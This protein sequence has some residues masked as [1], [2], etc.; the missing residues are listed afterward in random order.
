MRTRVNRETIRT[1]LAILSE[2][3]GR[4]RTIEKLLGEKFDSHSGED[5]AEEKV[6]HE[7][8]ER[9]SYRLCVCVCVCLCARVCV[10]VCVCV[11][12][13]VCVWCVGSSSGGTVT[14]RVRRGI[15]EVKKTKSVKSREIM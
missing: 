15:K 2:I 4:I 5:E 9:V 6:N 8:A 1:Y 11:R 12:A 13:C 7:D 3:F 14:M 10:R